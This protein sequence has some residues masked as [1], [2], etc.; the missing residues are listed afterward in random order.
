MKKHTSHKKKSESSLHD[1]NLEPHEV[2][3]QSHFA[4]ILT[5]M[6]QSTPGFTL[7]TEKFLKKYYYALNIEWLDN[8]I[9]QGGCNH[10]R[11]WEVRVLK[12]NTQPFLADGDEENQP[13]G[14]IFKQ[15]FRG[16][17]TIEKSLLFVFVCLM[18]QA[19]GEHSLQF[20]IRS[21]FRSLSIFSWHTAF[22]P[23]TWCRY[24]GILKMKQ[25]VTYAGNPMILKERC[26]SGILKIIS[27][28]K[29]RAV[30]GA[31]NMSG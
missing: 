4:Y 9:L 1:I 5:T 30:E 12:C 20:L 3:V 22:S 2:E 26:R 8:T 28:R 19:R 29:K 24:D 6:Y 11:D 27:A 23:W 10:V 17:G 16:N 18:S 31:F 7:A 25:F 14:A 15:F 21:A 13:F